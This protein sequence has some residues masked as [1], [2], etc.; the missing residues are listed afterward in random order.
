MRVLMK[1]CASTG[2]HR[3]LQR[4]FEKNGAVHN[5]ARMSRAISRRVGIAP[6]MS[7]GRAETVRSAFECSSSCRGRAKKILNRVPA[8]LLNDPDRLLVALVGHVGSPHPVAPAK[9]GFQ[10]A[11]TTPEITLTTSKITLTAPQ[12]EKTAPKIEMTAPKIDQTVPKIGLT[13][14]KK[15]LTAPRIDLT[16]PKMSLTA[17]KIGLTAPKIDIP[18]PISI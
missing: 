12:I 18:R 14:P 10:I 5:V 11:L 6:T 2:L 15:R 1:L 17:P 8:L 13:V 4:K 7:R 16:A 9:A 3:R